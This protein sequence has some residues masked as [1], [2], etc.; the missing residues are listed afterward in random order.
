MK[1]NYF[2]DKEQLSGVALFYIF[3]IFKILGLTKARF[4][5]LTLHSIC[6]HISI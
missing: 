2:L 6:C 4:F 3:A 1:S 5:D